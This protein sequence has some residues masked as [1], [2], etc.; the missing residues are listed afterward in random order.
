[1]HTDF[2]VYEHWRT[3]TNAPFYVGKGKLQRARSMCGRSA[4]HSRVV[5]KAKRDG[6]EIVV[7]IVE[8][9]L[10]EESA[11]A[12]EKMR[13][14][15]W[16]SL[17]VELVNHTDGGEGQTGLKHTEASRRKM[18]EGRRGERN[19]NYGKT[20]STDTREKIA[21]KARGRTVSEDAKKKLSARFSG[22]NNPMYGVRR[23][24]WTHSEETRLKMSA[25]QTGEKHAMYGRKHTPEALAKIA[26]GS[27]AYWARRRAERGVEVNG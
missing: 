4:R 2:L 12:F 27:R 18:S 3:D 9:N 17:G 24:G 22:E 6:F 13:I 10:P 14:S 23:T 5:A 11:F 1:M 19:H 15:Y 7:K 16:R 21:A 20:H 25:S 26:A 8:E